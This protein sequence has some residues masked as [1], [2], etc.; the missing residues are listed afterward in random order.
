MVHLSPDGVANL[1]D[2]DDDEQQNSARSHTADTNREN[3]QTTSSA[4]ASATATASA[5]LPQANQSSP[6]GDSNQGWTAHKH[7]SLTDEDL[8]DIDHRRKNAKNQQDDIIL[9]CDGFSIKRHIS[10]MKILV[11]LLVA[12]VYFTATYFLDFGNLESALTSSPYQVNFSGLRRSKFRLIDMLLVQLLT[13]NYTLGQS[14][15]SRFTNF[16]PPIASASP[17]HTPF[18]LPII[19]ERRALL[20]IEQFA[21]LQNVLAFGDSSLNV[22]PPSLCEGQQKLN[23]GSVR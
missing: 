22:D 12:I 1:E 10:M 2:L 11:A 16:M 18:E 7:A 23:F 8:M 19:S 4:A 6:D 5:T 9:R 3:E 20:E 14:S 21:N 15:L 13:Q 17:V